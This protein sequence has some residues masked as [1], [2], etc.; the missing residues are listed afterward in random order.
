VKYQPVEPHFDIAAAV[1]RYRRDT[2]VFIYLQSAC[3]GLP[4]YHHKTS[5]LEFIVSSRYDSY[6]KEFKD[7]VLN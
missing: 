4:A 3:G 5:M 2:A 1:F 7:I 6:H